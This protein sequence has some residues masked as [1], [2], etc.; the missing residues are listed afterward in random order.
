MVGFLNDLEVDRLHAIDEHGLNPAAHFVAEKIPLVMSDILGK[1]YAY[2]LQRLRLG[3]ITKL[4]V[5]ACL[6]HVLLTTTAD[7][8]E[9]DL[10]MVVDDEWHY[11]Y[12]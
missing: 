10:R 3:K 4:Q 12:G 8:A 5:L 7:Y 11:E 6:N 1:L 9:V 2:I